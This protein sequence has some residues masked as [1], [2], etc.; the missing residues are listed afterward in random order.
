MDDRRAAARALR[1]APDHPRR[2]GVDVAVVRTTRDLR[3]L[4]GAVFLSAAGDLLA[5]IVLAL[6]VHDLTGSGVAVSALM[7]TT[8]VPAVALAP[9]RSE[10]RR[11]GKECRSRWSP[12]H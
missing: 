12:Y 3:L 4:A 10:E 6:Q 7:A 1:S 11:V 8:L 2:S 9:L 5:L